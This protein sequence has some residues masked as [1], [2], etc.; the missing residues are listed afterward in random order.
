MNSSS[1]FNQIRSLQ[2]WADWRMKK[3]V[4]KRKA[5]EEHF[6]LKLRLNA[7][8]RNKILPPEIKVR[9]LIQGVSNHPLVFIAKN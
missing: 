5:L 1:S 9:H 2:L 4:R 6:E 8:R 7:L 3:D